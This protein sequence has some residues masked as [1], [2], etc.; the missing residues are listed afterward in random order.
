MCRTNIFRKLLFSAF[1]CVSFLIYG[2]NQ[3]ALSHQSFKYLVNKID[4]LQFERGSD[5]NWV[6]INAYIKKAKKENHLKNMFNGYKAAVFQTNHQK[7]DYADSAFWVAEEINE[8]VFTGR[9]YDL[10]AGVYYDL[11]DYKNA[12]DYYIKADAVLSSTQNKFAKNKILY[13]IG[14]VRLHL[15]HLEEAL[16]D[17]E[18]TRNYF[19]SID[20]PN[21]RLMLLRT[22][23]RLGEVYQLKGEKTKA[24]ALNLEGKKMALDFGEKYQESYFNLA[25]GIDGYWAEDDELAIQL[26]QKA[27]PELSDLGDFDVVEKAWFY[28]GKAYARLGQ[29]K[30]ALESFEKVDELFQEHGF[31]NPQARGSYEWLIDHYKEKKDKDQQLYYVNQLLNADQIN[32]HNAQGLS[33]Q[34]TKEYDT[35]SLEA[36]KAALEKSMNSKLSV[37]MSLI[38]VFF[39]LSVLFLGL[40]IRRKKEN[41]Q[42]T[43]QFEH[44]LNQQKK[45]ESIEQPTEKTIVI[46][47]K[48]EIPEEVVAEILRR[49]AKFETEQ[50]YLNPKVDLPYLANQFKTNTA[51]LSKVINSQKEKS[52]TA[53]L[54]ELRINYLI[55]L[56]KKDPTYRQHSVAALAE[57]TGYSTSR[58]FSAAFS[59]VGKMKPSDFLKRIQEEVGVI[60]E[61]AVAA[62]E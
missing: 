49:L 42:L 41:Q 61:N 54:N 51:Y 31:L 45:S 18:A 40:F 28:I 8:D 7:M 48:Q 50:A 34:L 24:A 56:L 2:Q 39:M 19:E 11:R 30:E 35:K 20:D 5:L 1:F 55:D 3:D 57:L 14:V 10:K 36:A 22:I 17:F 23:Y 25:M 4:S 47:K 38:A 62:F 43:K 9:A 58:Q 13:N 16:H 32:A 33:Y 53:Y 37:T 44:L 60:G 12:L 21:H 29:E 46:S 6:Y 15:G 27:T 52:F 26:L 59:E